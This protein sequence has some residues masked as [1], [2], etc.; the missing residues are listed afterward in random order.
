MAQFFL[1][2]KQKGEGCDYT[3]GCGETI[4]E[5]DGETHKQALKNVYEFFEEEQQYIDPESDSSLE[6]C[7]LFELKK[8][9]DLDELQEKFTEEQEK[10][11][12]DNQEEC[13]RKEYERLKKKYGKS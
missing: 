1:Y 10:E 6:E 8:T 2:M 3:I 13:E 12:E 11:E 9:I 4:Q 7:Y 5:I